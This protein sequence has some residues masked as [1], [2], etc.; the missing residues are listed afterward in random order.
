ML[1]VAASLLVSQAG[2]VHC[3]FQ[4]ENTPL[5]KNEKKFSP[6]LLNAKLCEYFLW[7]K[8]MMNVYFN[9]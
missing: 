1:V 2:H 9:F 4:L 3:P 7:H 6:T 5:V 8:G